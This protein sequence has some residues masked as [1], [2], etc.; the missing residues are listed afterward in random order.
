MKHNING[1]PA[2]DICVHN[3][4][5]YYSLREAE[6]TQQLSGSC[7]ADI[8]LGYYT[9]VEGRYMDLSHYLFS[10]YLKVMGRQ[11]CILVTL[12]SLLTK[13]CNVSRE[14]SIN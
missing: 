1:I 4:W 7:F 13:L 5:V 12:L 3:V 10:K 6:V 9:F 2:R 14:N 11:G 8:Q